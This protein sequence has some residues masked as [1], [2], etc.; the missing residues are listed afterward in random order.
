[1]TA[2]SDLISIN[3]SRLSTRSRDEAAEYVSRMFVTHR[4][5]FGSQQGSGHFRVQSA[6][7]VAADSFGVDR[8][9]ISL[10]FGSDTDPFG[11]VVVTKTLSGRLQV[12]ADHEECRLRPGDLCIYPATMP[13]SLSW[14]D[15]EVVSLRLPL[16]LIERVAQ[17]QTGISATDLHF[18]SMRP[19]SPGMGRYL[20]NVVG[21]FYRQLLSR[22]AGHK[23]NGLVA[24]QLLQTAGAAVLTTIP[25]TTMTLAHQPAPGRVAPAALRRAVIY[26]DAHADRPITVSDIAGAS[27][28]GPRS[29]QY[30]FHRYY[31]TSPMGYLRR[32]RLHHAHRELK[33]ADPTAGDTVADIACRWGFSKPGRFAAAY[34]Q[35][36]GN[37]P[38][39]TLRS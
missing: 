7:A 6:T 27:G 20:G 16:E 25:N 1:M 31:E 28:V 4:P 32:V 24:E 36:F 30:A 29:L 10:N 37:D 21:L 23:L 17:Q 3:S 35:L 33:G 8:C 9:K 14:S 12:A 2:T 11:C 19:L 13:M 22:D 5:Q 26:I 15:L 38:S 39:H 18:Q 34:R